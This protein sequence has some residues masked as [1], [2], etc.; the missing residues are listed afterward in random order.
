[1]RLVTWNC[2]GALRRKFAAVDALDADVLVIQECE[3]PAQSTAEYQSWAGNYVWTGYGKSKGIG[4]FPRRGQGIE[5]L[6]WP[7]G[8][9]GLFL[10]VRLNGALNILAVWT[11]GRK[12]PT[13]YSYI[14][15]FWHYLQL[16]GH[17]LDPDTIICGDFNS[18][19]IWDKTR[20]K[21]NHSDCVRELA[22]LGFQSLF[23]CT[24]GDA[25]GQEGQPTFFLQRNEAKPYHIDYAFAHHNRLED[26]RTNAQVGKA[27]DWLPLSDHM[28]VIVDL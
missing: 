17:R 16:N 21:R 6:D 4:V 7:Q 19:Q 12:S 15:Q 1:M 14:A 9:G 20:R 5:R 2:N 27:A 3:D 18:N 23:H 25:Q 26:S 24:S 22:D 10:P 28:P 13:Q 8:E 11:L